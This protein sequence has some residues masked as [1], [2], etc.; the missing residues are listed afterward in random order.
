MFLRAASAAT[1]L[2]IGLGV[3]G[4]QALAQYYPLPPPYPAQSYPLQ[5][6]QLP[7]LLDDDL[8]ALGPPAT[9]GFPGSRPPQPMQPG[10]QYGGRALYPEDVEPYAPP[11]PAFAYPN[12]NPPPGYGAPA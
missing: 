2:L 12:G 6:R 10:T 9:F 11:P 8:D 1:V 3:P 7:P 5:P 4:G